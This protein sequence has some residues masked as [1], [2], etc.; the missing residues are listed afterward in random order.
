MN[1]SINYHSP[2]FEYTVRSSLYSPKYK[3]KIGNDKLTWSNDKGSTGEIAYSDIL[4]VNLLYDPS[5]GIT[6]RYLISIKP[7]KHKRIYISNLHYNKLILED[8]SVEFKK[9]VFNL[10]R[11]MVDV[12]P[13]INFYGGSI[14]LWRS[15]I[16]IA[17]L[18]FSILLFAIIIS[19][20]DKSIS[21]NW[22]LLLKFSLI[23]IYVPIIIRSLKRNKP[24]TYNPLSIPDALLP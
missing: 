12:N 14:L 3:F 21:L 2:E 8:Q 4:S 16:F 20:S 22:S 1:E 24:R 17:L 9:F 23:A 18:F 10:H 7:R 19:F 5:P 15:Y 13:N 6:N 11:A